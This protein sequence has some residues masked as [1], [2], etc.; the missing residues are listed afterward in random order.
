MDPRKDYYKILGV[1]E[2]ASAAEI[3]KA[4]R[5]LAK[6]Y[7]PD[8]HAGDKQAENRFKDISEAY[9]ILGDSKK[10]Q[11]YDMMR[12][13][14]FASGQA[15]G[16]GDFSNGGFRVNFGGSNV[17]G[18][19]FDDLLG[20]LFG[21]GGRRSASASPFG[22]D[23]FGG[24]RRRASQRGA[25]V[26]TKITIPFEMAAR[27]GE[28]IVKTPSGKK[29]KLKIPAGTEDGKKIKMS[30]QGWPSPQAGGVPGDLYITIQVAPHPRFERKG[31]DIYTTEYINFAQALFGTEIQVTTIDGKKVKLKIPAGTDGGKLFRLKGLGIHSANGQG[32]HYARIE[33]NTP[34]K[35]SGSLKRSFREWAQNAGLLR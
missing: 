9:S 25:D 24:S 7:H 12:R 2:S 4:Y 3:K 28:T 20:N 26:Q 13:N 22:E 19:M 18:S 8:K 30:G 21:F 5:E 11:E 15:G 6:K 10:R 23:V 14:P 32:D 33:I 29:V 34:K 27:G 1:S 31:N 16:F 17:S 35:L